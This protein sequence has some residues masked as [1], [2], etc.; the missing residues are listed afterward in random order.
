[1]REVYFDT[2]YTTN[3]RLTFLLCLF[4]SARI[5]VFLA[6]ISSFVME[7]LYPSGAI[8]LPLIEV[9]VF[10]REKVNTIAKTLLTKKAESSRNRENSACV[11]LR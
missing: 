5:L 3:L 10:L 8:H 6:N 4:T 7:I 1:M 9:G 11:L 2:K